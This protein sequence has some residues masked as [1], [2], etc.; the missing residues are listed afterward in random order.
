MTNI[1]AS[2]EA[3]LRFAYRDLRVVLFDYKVLV[4]SIA[5]GVAAVTGVGALHGFVPHRPCA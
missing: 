5:I 2:I 4:L 1:R 3:A